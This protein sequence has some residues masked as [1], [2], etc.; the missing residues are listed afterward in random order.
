MPNV[1][2]A[3]GSVGRQAVVA[4]GGV[5]VSGCHGFSVFVP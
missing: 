1:P 2:F 5:Q 4:G 3:L